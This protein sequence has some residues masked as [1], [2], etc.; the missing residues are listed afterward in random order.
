M[1]SLPGFPWLSWASDDWS[2]TMLLKKG[3]SLPGE[4]GQALL[5]LVIAINEQLRKNND[6]AREAGMIDDEKYEEPA[7]ISKKS[8]RSKK[9]KFER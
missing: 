3:Y 4:H 7:K 6:V 9:A 8:K 2:G 1:P 5:S